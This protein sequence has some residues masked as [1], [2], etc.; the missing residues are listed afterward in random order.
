MKKKIVLSIVIILIL[1]N[2][3]LPNFMPISLA[4]NQIEQTQGTPTVESQQQGTT[5]TNNQVTTD[6]GSSKKITTE[7]QKART[8]I[9]HDG[10][11][12]T[13]GGKVESKTDSKTGTITQVGKTIM[14]EAA[15]MASLIVKILIKA[16]ITPIPYALQ[17]IM[18][19]TGTG[20]NESYLKGNPVAN[21]NLQ[22]WFDD[23][24]INWFTIQ[25][26]VFGKV[27]LFNVDFFDVETNG[28][29]VNSNVKSSIAVWYNTIFMIAQA[30][31]ILVLLY[32]GIRMAMATNPED[33]V[34]Y[35]KMFKNWVVGFAMLFLLRYGIIIVLKIS[36][37]LITLIPESISGKN[38][39]TEIINKS[40]NVF[41][42]NESAWTT[43]LYAITYAIIVGYEVYFFIKYFKRVLVMGFLIIIAPLITVTYAID[44]ADDGKAQA[45]ETWRKMFISN[46]LM[47]PVHALLYTIFIF[48]ASNIALKAPMIAVVF[49]IGILKG[50]D[51]FNKLFNLQKT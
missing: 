31:S 20:D 33:R 44:K 8:E 45:F 24:Q 41:D 2:T 11:T 9:K 25:K 47:Q 29:D 28:S 27:P 36:N 3:L 18:L 48:S 39:E 46:A 16:I 34:N 23:A 6:S 38:F 30:L 40:L 22:Q 51:I 5:S 1:M 49:F 19:V 7:G 15:D 35:K 17:F 12:D 43:L 10:F 50:E 42:N 37:W 21:S 32:I 13:S 4:N 26:A 14:G